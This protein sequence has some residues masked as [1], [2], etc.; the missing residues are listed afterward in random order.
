MSPQVSG[1]NPLLNS[2]VGLGVISKF[3]LCRVS[4]WVVAFADSSSSNS[5][6]K[7]SVE[8]FQVFIKQAGRNDGVN[9]VSLH[10]TPPHIF[11]DVFPDER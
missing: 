4:T 1:L 2:G 7:L 3:G 5:E 6:Q 9:H 10:P 8:N 11:G